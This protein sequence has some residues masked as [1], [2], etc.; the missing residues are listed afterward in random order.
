MLS[1]K[2]GLTH[3][4]WKQIV[5][6]HLEHTWIIALVQGGFAIAAGVT[7]F[8]GKILVAT[9][10]SSHSFNSGLN[11]FHDSED[12]SACFKV[13]FYFSLKRFCF[14]FWV[15][16]FC[17][18]IKSF[19]PHNNFPFFYMNIQPLPVPLFSFPL[20]SVTFLLEFLFVRY[21]QNYVLNLSH[22]SYFLIY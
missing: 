7:M 13:L 16:K 15:Y 12:E 1:L 9:Q 11:P 22:T 5:V 14:Q 18:A 21:F 6:S 17:A 19:V 4:V 3:I 10:A 20:L 8:C 2:V